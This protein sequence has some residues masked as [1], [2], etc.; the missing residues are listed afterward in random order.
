MLGLGN[1]PTD[2]GFNAASDCFES[3]VRPGVRLN[4]RPVYFLVLHTPA[5]CKASSL[6]ANACQ[7][8]C[9]KRAM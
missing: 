4:V 3:N 2:A 1:K 9:T 6:C 8:D 5:E 7:R